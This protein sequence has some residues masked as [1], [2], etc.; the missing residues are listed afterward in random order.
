MK[1]VFLLLSGILII[2]F[3]LNA[4]VFIVDNNIDS[5]GPYTSLQSA[6]NAASNGDTLMIQ[7]SPTS[8]GNLDMR[9]SLT[10]IGAGYHPSI[11]PLSPTELGELTIQF[12]RNVKVIGIKASKIYIKG[13]TV[14]IERCYGFIKMENSKQVTLVNNIITKL[15]MNG[16]IKQTNAIKNNI[17][18]ETKSYYNSVDQLVFDHNIFTG[19]EHYFKN[20]DIKNSIFYDVSPNGYGSTHNTGT[21]YIN[22]LAYCPS[23]CV[24]TFL[25]TNGNNA[26]SCLN[27]TNPGFVSVSS[28]TF[29]YNYDYHLSS[30]SAGHNYATDG[31]DIGIYG[32]I[33]PFPDG[34]SSGSG[35]QT[36]QEAPIPQIYD[37]TIQN[38]TVSQSDTLHVNV[39]VQIQR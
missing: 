33:D 34:G 1:K 10:I 5:P 31:T 3:V 14:T 30:T 13:D 21:D 23:G 27:H 6:Y 8:Y 26:A 25:T 39:K 11:A 19:T 7:G 16:S 37:Y 18:S 24:D 15:Q 22:C 32:G 38:K 35:F 2:P 20:A 36:S 9:K 29:D 17:I 12:C 4:T 28:A